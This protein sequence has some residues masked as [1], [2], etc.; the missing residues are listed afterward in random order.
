M[1]LDLLEC[2]RNFLK[3]LEIYTKMP[4]TQI[5]TDM[6]V[7]I[8]VELLLVFT[9]ATKQV[10]QGRFSMCAITY[11]LSMAECAVEKFARKLLGESKIEAILQ[12]LDRLTQDEQLDIQ[13]YVF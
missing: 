13:S 10:E 8:M 3:R 7:K 2:L 9:L 5:I 6:M 1:Q 11:T 4:P 12:R